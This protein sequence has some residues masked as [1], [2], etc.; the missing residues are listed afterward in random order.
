MNVL[1]TTFPS[2]NVEI[3]KLGI[4]VDLA[5]MKRKLATT[6]INPSR[7]PGKHRKPPPNP[8]FVKTFSGE[9][10]VQEQT[11][12]L[13]NMFVTSVKFSMRGGRIFP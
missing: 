1:S 4:L 12:S 9:I 7:I 8:G 6:K 13:N 10:A 3:T 5:P 11:A 2:T